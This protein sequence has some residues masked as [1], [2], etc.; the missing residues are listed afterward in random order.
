MVDPIDRA[1]GPVTEQLDLRGPPRYVLPCMKME[2]EVASEK[3][4][5]NKNYMMNKVQKRKTE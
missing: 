3:F 4:C 5:F 2:A 1:I